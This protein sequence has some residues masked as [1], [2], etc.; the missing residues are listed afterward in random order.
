MKGTGMKVKFWG[1]RGFIPAPGESTVRYGG[2]TICLEAVSFSNNQVI[3]DAGTGSRR[4]G[5][6]MMKEEFGKG[7][8]ECLFLIS[9]THWDHIQGFPFFPPIFI[10]GNK[11]EFYGPGIGPNGLETL[12][13][14]QMN[15]N[16][17]PVHTLGNLGASFNFNKILQNNA[18]FEWKDIKVS[19]IF[20]DHARP[21]QVIGY[22]LSDPINSIAFI[23]DVCYSDEKEINRVVEFVKDCDIL[24]HDTA[25]LDHNEYEKIKAQHSSIKTAVKIA[26]RAQVKRLVPFHYPHDSSDNE[27]DDIF[28][29]LD[30][31]SENFEFIPA[32]EGMVL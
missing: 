22:R 18:G 6:R 20:L 30:L 14:G 21:R 15:P 5:L 28:N 26:R 17:N 1:V 3:I 23:T 29:S 7:K 11:F 12:L 31:S 4:L 9:H 16:F 24:I 10:P 8:G 25:Y 27:L 19:M 2:N 13:E 32:K